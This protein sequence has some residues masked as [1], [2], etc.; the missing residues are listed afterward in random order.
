MG[1]YLIHAASKGDEVNETLGDF[2]PLLAPTSRRRP[3]RRDTLCTD[4]YILFVPVMASFF[5]DITPPPFRLLSGLFQS[6]CFL[7]VL[8][9]FRDDNALPHDTIN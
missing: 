8:L 7:F 5:Y 3:L 9:T 1:R 6:C 4:M 2:L